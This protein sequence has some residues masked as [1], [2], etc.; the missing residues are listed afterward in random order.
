MQNEPVPAEDEEPDVT[1]LTLE[2]LKEE[3]RARNGH[4]HDDEHPPEDERPADKLPP[5][6]YEDVFLAEDEPDPAELI[7][8]LLHQGSKMVLGGGSKSFKTWMLLDMATAVSSGANWMGFATTPT[9]VLYI[10]L[11]IQRA[12]TRKRV[13]WIRQAKNQCGSHEL[14]IWNLRGHCCDIV[15]LS[16]EITRRAKAGGFGLIIIDPIYKTLGDRDEN[17]A[18][19]VANL[20][21]ELEKIAVETCAAI[22]FGA[23]FSKGNQSA[24]ESIDRIGGSGVFARDPDT[25][26]VLTRHKEPDCFTVEL[27][28]RNL[29]PCEPFVV[30][31]AWPLMQRDSSLRPE[32]LKEMR[33]SE[34]KITPTL[35]EEEAKTIALIPDGGERRLPKARLIS[36]MELQIRIPSRRVRT[37]LT[38]LL[39]QGKLHSFKEPRSR[40]N[41]LEFIC[42]DAQAQT[43]LLPTP[44]M[45]NKPK[46]KKRK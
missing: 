37:V 23:H 38:G 6:D 39:A 14:A 44:N 8:G 29:P 36:L 34:A 27:T 33:K 20:L 1:K 40:T 22:V 15:N 19:D 28:L 35:D 17:K 41:P 10:N 46:R 24:K 42:L 7:E 30:R 18:G 43:D 26:M 13:R 3:A 31:W 25:I 32:D 4:E 45:A 16:A 11:E 5:F 21:N 9:R 2:D 12:F